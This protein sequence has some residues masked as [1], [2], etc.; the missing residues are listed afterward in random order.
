MFSIEDILKMDDRL[1]RF[2]Y[3]FAIKGLLRDLMHL[4]FLGNLT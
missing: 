1:K 3:V 2:S 4:T